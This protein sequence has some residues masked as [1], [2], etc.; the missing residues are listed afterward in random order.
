MDVK[1]QHGMTALM[2]AAEYGRPEIEELLI[3][4][5]AQNAPSDK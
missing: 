5:R 1:D 2:Y 3:L 4:A